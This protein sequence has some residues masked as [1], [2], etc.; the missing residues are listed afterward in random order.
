MNYDTTE[1][2][3]GNGIIFDIKRNVASIHTDVNTSTKKYEFYDETTSESESMRVDPHIFFIFETPYHSA[4]AHWVLESALFLPY[5]KHFTNAR[6]LVNANRK[7]IINN[8][9]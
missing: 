3:V 6:V 7:E 4:F 9:F 2:D 8:Y 1:I 5:F